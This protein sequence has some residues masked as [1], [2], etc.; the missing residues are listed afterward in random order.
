LKQLEWGTDSFRQR[1]ILTVYSLYIQETILNAKDKCNC[2][3]NQQV[4]ITQ[5]ILTTI[6]GMYII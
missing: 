5:E 3:I 6:I 1:K 2:A 4:H